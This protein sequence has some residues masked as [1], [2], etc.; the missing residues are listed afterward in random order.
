MV[1]IS[2][3]FSQKI[4]ESRLA[5]ELEDIKAKVISAAGTSDGKLLALAYDN[6]SVKIF[7]LEGKKFISTFKTSFTEVHEFFITDDRKVILIESKNLKIYDWNSG[8]EIASITLSAKLARADFHASSNMLVIG[9]M[10]G[11]IT[12]L[13]LNSMA[14]IYTKKYDGFMVNAVTIE[15]SGKYA[16]ASFYAL[17]QKSTVRIIEI[18]TGEV[19]KTFEK[20]NFQGLYYDE[21]GNLLAYG[22]GGKGFWFRVYDPEYAV[23]KYFETPTQPFGYSVGEYSN[24]KALFTTFSL[25]LDV[26]DIEKEE[27]IYTSLADKKTFYF[28]PGEYLY[29]KII[30]LSPTKF[31][32]SYSKF[33]ILRLY[34]TSIDDVSAFFFTDGGDKHCVVS[35][36]GRIDGDIEA[37]NTVYWTS[38]RSNIKTSLEQTFER[39]YT[40]G[41][42]NSI[43]ASENSELEQF[44]I[45]SFN[46]KLPVLK[47]ATIGDVPFEGTDEVAINTKMIKLNLTVSENVEEVAEIRVYHNTKLV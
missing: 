3:T 25:T 33:N 43:I 42:F 46:Q 41:L 40:P 2:S 18:S 23:V 44:D 21:K 22:W 12:T 38:R 34:D 4:D 14:P 35:K 29:P 32:F 17:S 47:I 27:F 15:P 11:K 31:L 8:S 16:A 36:D 7:D 24:N 9:H 39:A 28:K 6:S 20:E 1:T 37:L 5:Y 45:D 13:D 26:Y 19:I 10:G 30:K